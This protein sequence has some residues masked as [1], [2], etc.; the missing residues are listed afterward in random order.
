MQSALVSLKTSIH[1]VFV[2]SNG[3]AE[4][5]AA[6]RS[7]KGI[8]GQGSVLKL[9]FLV[10]SYGAQLLYSCLNYLGLLPLRVCFQKQRL[11][12]H[13]APDKR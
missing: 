9:G 3:L 11:V 1:R 6:R 7:Q 13:M 8:W 4:W 2:L 5:A 12:N 10:V